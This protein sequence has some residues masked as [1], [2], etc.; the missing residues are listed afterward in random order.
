MLTTARL[1][2]LL[3]LVPAAHGFVATAELPDLLTTLDGQSVTTEA[4]WRSRRVELKALLQ[5][6]ILGTLPPLDSTPRLTSASAVNHTIAHGVASCYVRLAYDAN[7]TAVVLDVELAWPAERQ[8]S[9]GKA[10]GPGL[11]LFLT[12]WNHRAWAM[13]GVQRGYMMVLYP[14]A[15]TRDASGAFRAAFPGASFRKILA[16]AFVASRVLDYVL[17]TTTGTNV[18]AGLPPHFIPAVD[19]SRVCITGHSRN[20]KQ[21]LIAAAFDERFSA[22]VGSSP[23]TPI[24]APVRFSSPD[25]NGETA[26]FVTPHRDWWLPSLRSYYGREHELPAD[27]HMV[28]AL[29]APRFA[30]LATARSD[31][32]GDTTFADE[33]NV[34]ANMRVWSLLN[35]PRAL[36]IKFR[37]GR[38]HGFD[39]PQNYVD[40]FDYSGRIAGTDLLF[41]LPTERGGALPHAFNWTAWNARELARGVRP[42]L[43]SPTAPLTARIGWLLGSSTADPASSTAETST[44]GLVIGEA[45]AESSGVGGEWDF[46]AKLMMHDSFRACRKSGATA[47]ARI[48]NKSDRALPP[49]PVAYA[50]CKYNVTRL[51]FSFGAYITASLFVPCKDPR[52]TSVGDPTAPL[53]VVMLL[54]GFSYSMG[55][56]GMCVTYSSTYYCAFCTPFVHSRYPRSSVLSLARS[57]SPM[58]AYILILLDTASSTAPQMVGLS[59]R[60]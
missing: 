28:L 37:E 18:T 49:T 4:E 25:F 46:K 7:D 29:I 30:M 57:L 20:G 16:R 45:Y 12:Q 34:I 47:T 1:L 14:G 21:S 38:H 59:T 40:W 33:M 52:C 55:Y 36:H 53:P 31:S 11:P 22:V 6:H 2:L 15:D 26:H 44:G 35:A 51:S 27:G 42:P 9:G 54:P 3:T 56:T 60:S 8:R 23:G 24:A 10:A 32:E 19:P 43:P 41:P 50:Q 48:L 17:A 5:E 58:H 39:D 13:Q